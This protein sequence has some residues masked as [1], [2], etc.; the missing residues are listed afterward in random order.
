[1]FF[2]LLI[3]WLIDG[4]IKK[5]QVLH[6][7]A[8]SLIAWTLAEIVKRLIPTARP[9][10]VNGGEPLTLTVMADG[11]FPSGHTSAAFALAV[12]I[13]LHDRKIGWAYII[14]AIMVGIARVL[15]NVHY[16]VDILAGAILGMLT[17]FGVEKVH[18]FSLLKKWTA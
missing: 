2:G 8:A 10:M 11:S 7:L 16:P 4:R 13:W 9:F 5:E 14:A 12:T 6:A 3:L 1:M 15:A 17:A 18:L